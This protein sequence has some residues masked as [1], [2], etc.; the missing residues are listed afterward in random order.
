M[1]TI[2]NQ[3]YRVKLE[4]M[5]TD[6][7]TKDEKVSDIRVNGR[8]IGG[9]NPI[10][11]DDCS[12]YDCSSNENEFGDHIADTILR[13]NEKGLMKFELDYSREHDI[14]LNCPYNG[15]IVQA[16]ASI[17]LDPIEGKAFQYILIYSDLPLHLK[18]IWPCSND[19]YQCHLFSRN[20]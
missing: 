18:S 2:P 13:S 15:G 16:A 6:M 5:R 8:S 17:S 9:C 3:W 20:G 1:Y 10:G 7:D 12:F 14:K 19:D 11:R 4:V